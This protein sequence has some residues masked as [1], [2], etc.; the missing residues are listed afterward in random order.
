MFHYYFVDPDLRVEIFFEK[1]RAAENGDVDFETGDISTSPHLYWRF[2]KT[3]CRAFS[4]FNYC[5]GIKKQLLKYLL[6]CTFI[7]SLLNSFNFP[8][9]SSKFRKIY[10]LRLLRGLQ[11]M[12][13]SSK[14]VPKVLN[15]K[16]NLKFK[17]AFTNRSSCTMVF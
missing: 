6:T 9:Y 1:Q 8:S 11:E 12:I 7:H 14:P 17:H 10:T 4:L 5:F 2:K 13:V 15:K 16:Y 3:A